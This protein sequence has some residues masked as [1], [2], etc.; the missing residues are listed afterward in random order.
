[1]YAQHFDIVPQLPPTG[2]GQSNQKGLYLEPSTGIHLLKRAHRSDGSI[3]GDVIPLAQLQTLVD[4]VPWFGKQVNKQL[5]K[6][7]VLEY[8]SEFWL[9]K[10]FEKELFYAFKGI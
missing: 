2:Q 6:E 8:S 4:L 5:A 10:Y 7:T 9:N 1:M 3:M